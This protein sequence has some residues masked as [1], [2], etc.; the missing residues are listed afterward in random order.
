MVTGQQDRADLALLNSMHHV[1]GAG[2]LC[3]DRQGCMKGTRREV[4]FQLEQWSKDEQDKRV[5]WLNGLAGTGKSTIAQTFAEMCFAD[6]K[7][8]ASFFCSRDF[9]DRSSLRSIF[10]TIA[11]QVAYRYP[12]FRQELLQVLA[13]NPD[14]GRESL[15]SQMEK[16][17]IG[18]FQVTQAPTLVIID[19]LDECQDEEPASALLSVLSRY[20]DD[21]PLVKFLITGRPELRIRSG[22]RLESLRPHT[23]VFELH[24][25]EPVS[26]DSDIKLFLKTRFI[27]VAK[28]RSDC[29][30]G[31]DWPGP[32][33]IDI[34][35]KKAAGF[36]IFAS[37]VVKFIS[38]HYHPPDERLAL[39]VSL[40]LDTSH[41]AKLG[42]DPLYTQVLGQAFQDVDFHDHQLYS[43]LKSVVGAVI[44]IFHPLSI[45]T[46]SDLLIN[47]GTPTRMTSSL[48]TLHSLLLVPDNIDN[49]IRIF[50]KSFPDFL[51]DPGRCTDDRFFIDPPVCHNE[52]LLSCLN[53]MSKRLRRNICSL[54]DQAA[55]SG[56]N[57]LPTQRA[58]HI[59]DALEYACCFWTKHLAKVSS[60][61]SGVEEACR[62]I[63]TFFETGFLFWIEVLILMGKLDIGIY[64]LNDIQ[65]WCM[66]VSFVFLD[67]QLRPVLISVQ[68]GVPDKW[69]SCSK[70]F[71]LENFDTICNSPSKIY[72]T[73]L[74]LCP[75]S[76]W[77]HDHYATRFPLKVKVVVGLAEWGACTRTVS[78]IDDHTLTL[79]YQ[80]NTIATGLHNDINIF[81]TLTG[82][83]T[84]VLSGHTGYVRSLVF[85]SDGTLLV[86]GSQD[87]TI[88][89][90]DV[91]TGG[92]VKTFHGHTGTILSVSISVGNTMIASGSADETICLWNIG[93]REC[94]VKKEHN[95]VRTVSFSPTNPQ[96]LLSASRDGTVQKWNTDGHQIG[97]PI[98]GSHVAFS[99]DGTQFVSC[100][101]SAVTIWNTDSGEAVAEF[102][103]AQAEFSYCCFSPDGKLIACASV[104]TIYLW[105]ITGPVPHLIKTLVGHTDQITSL[106]FPSLTLIS[107]SED[108]SVKFWE[109]GASSVNPAAPHTES[110]PLT[111]AP[112]RA[113]SLQAKDGLAF[114]VDSA[115]VVRIWDILT[116]LC[117]ESFETQAKDIEI[118]DIQLIGGRLVI[119]GCKESPSQGWMV[120]VWDA[121]KSELQTMDGPEYPPR[122]LRISGDGSRVFCMDDWDLQ[123]WSIQTGVSGGMASIQQGYPYHLDP[124]WIDGSKVIVRCG[125]SLTLG[126]DFGIPGSTP[127]RISPTSSDRPHLDF[128]GITS[129]ETAGKIGI[130]D[131]ATGNMVFQLTGKTPT[132]VQWDGCYLIAG[133]DTGEVL[134][135][136]FSTMLP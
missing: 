101:G 82:T 74:A 112:I 119:V 113:V 130:E 92:V 20:V 8:G 114:S 136:D 99:Q 56:I 67:F 98:P 46:L 110:T 81:D 21:I 25:V 19:A 54:D 44:L 40:P 96:L 125:R 84:A 91:Q 63:S 11:F 94:H 29:N 104:H 35:C 85:S 75:S 24:E 13:E 36:F 103:L 12:S 121:K 22:F 102:H 79:A 133:Y 126:W 28:N 4:L 117:K 9:E 118:G 10:P 95:G 42:I 68:I 6:G 78:C 89:L 73:A 27:D 37:T 62:A 134:I 45:K 111:S 18:P 66:L 50:H 58:I 124:L 7:L 69:T 72:D 30:L 76:S 100:K 26:V 39:I 87:E 129:D 47:C 97:S 90:W 83:Q 55:L 65:Q 15:C 33:N 123:A 107:A 70:H 115:G 135:L 116:G 43:H 34:L 61:S 51:T 109:I 120:Y 86:S 105:D 108:E 2:H 16:L 31:E 48:R 49:P 106:I 71:I 53:V 88:K 59:G 77:L 3:G 1:A 41:E 60:S 80:S 38:S 122:G 17:I 128:I 23:E 132:A 93:T 57:D 32:H 131:R 127:L 5:F 52:I 14:I 64:A